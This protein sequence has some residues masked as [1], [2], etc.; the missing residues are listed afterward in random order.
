M[1]L[2]DSPAERTTAA[3]DVLLSLAAAGA[4][5][6]L[7]WRPAPVSWKL[8]LWS[9]TF[10]LIS[11]AAAFG[12]AYHGL[13]LA[14]K[15]RGWLWG[16]LTACLSMTISLFVVGV[17][18]DAFGRQTAGRILPLMLTAGV[19]VFA[20]SRIFEGLF[21]VFIV[22]QALALVLALSLYV[23]LA[24]QGAAAGA[25]W[26]AAG[27]TA[28]MIAAGIQTVRSLKVKWIWTF[29]HN[30]IFHLVQFLGVILLCV[31]LMHG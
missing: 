19:L 16:I 22:Y 14:E 6:L 21:R 2:N 4:V 15:L 23:W 24:A 31:G 8:Q 12:A 3:T 18:H 28:S 29:D 9:G 5:F 27:V 10:A 11:L 26:M 30:G 7:Q 20:V 25:G 17:F 1:K 13:V